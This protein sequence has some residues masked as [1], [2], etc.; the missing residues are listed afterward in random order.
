VVV[1]AAAIEEGSGGA[2]GISAEDL[3]AFYEWKAMAQAAAAPPVQGDDKDK[4]DDYEYD[5]GAVALPL[6]EMT[7]GLGFA[8]VAFGAESEKAR[9][10]KKPR[11]QG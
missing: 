10:K 5:L 2:G 1:A 8:A 7:G 11:D 9:A 6:E 4:R 3:R